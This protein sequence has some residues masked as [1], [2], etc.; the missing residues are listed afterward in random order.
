MTPEQRFDLKARLMRELSAWDYADRDLVFGEVHLPLSGVEPLID[1]V[2]MA[3][4]DQVTVMRSLVFGVGR[5]SESVANPDPVPSCWNPG[6]VRVFISHSAKHKVFVSE[7]S[8]D[9]AVAGIHGFVAHETMTVAKSWQDQIENALKSAQAF[10]AFVHPEFNPSEWCQQEA[11]WA[12][13]RGIP[14]FAVRLGDDPKGFLASKQWPSLVGRPANE[15]ATSI[16]SWLAGQPSFTRA[17]VGGLISS[18]RGEGDF[19]TLGRIAEQI[20]AIN[21]MTPDEYDQIDRVYSANASL[22]N[23]WAA[24]ATF[25]SLYRDAG[26]PW[27]P[28]P[29][30]VV[31]DD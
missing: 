5:P 14:V 20:G 6:Q 15:V 30:L 12:I 7:V 1:I 25:R 3:S 11:G 19:K 2:S 27:P 31:D 23:A 29:T 26:R 17:I 28:R 16:R 10:V 18:L 13:G 9:L 24:K 22:Q 4:D 8:S 21:S